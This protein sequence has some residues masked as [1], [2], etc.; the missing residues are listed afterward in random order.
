[1]KD[2]L[3]HLPERKRGELDR[4]VE[5]IRN[6]VP[7]TEMII[8]FGSHARGDWVDDITV[9]GNTTYEYASDFD[10][11]VIV[12]SQQ[13]ADRIT[14]WHNIEDKAAKHPIQTPVTIIAHDINFINKRLEKGHYFFADIK[15]EGIAL[16]DSKKCQLAPPRQ[17]PPKER[18]A[19]AKEYFKDWFKS[20]NDFYLGYKF[21]FGKKKYNKAAFMLHQTAESFYITML[22][23]HTNYKPKTHML[24]KLRKMAGGRDPA[25]LKIFPTAT[26][27]EKRLY[28]LLKQAY[29]RARYDSDYIITKEELK[30][31]AKHI[32]TLRNQT[33]KS[34]KKKMTSFT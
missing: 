28:D 14:L 13:L 7:Q 20:S 10:I 26:D 5:I 16:Y 32:K 22:L 18:L 17:L 31:L 1:M 19:Q 15:K 8:L 34:C 2:S 3:D 12:D 11:L 4:I 9:K 21:Y 24:V 30:H 29:V 25:F 6:K 27:Q 33:K 23:V